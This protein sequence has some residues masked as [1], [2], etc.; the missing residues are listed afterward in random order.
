M[1]NLEG[2][3]HPRFNTRW[4]SLVPNFSMIRL[5]L[6]VLLLAVAVHSSL[7]EEVDVSLK[8]AE[9]SVQKTLKYPAALSDP[10]EAT[11]SDVFRISF[12][13][14]E[15]LDHVFLSM[16]GLRSQTTFVIGKKSSTSFAL[17][18]PIGSDPFMQGIQGY[19]DTYQLA[20]YITSKSGD[21]LKYPLGKMAV[22]VDE[23][24]TRRPSWLDAEYTQQPRIDH[25]FKPPQKM[26]SPT[27]SHVFTGLVVA[28]WLFFLPFAF[29][30]GLNAS[31]AARQVTYTL[32]A[33]L[34]LGVL[35]AWTFLFFL[36]FTEFNIF[37]LMGY[38]S[39]LAV[40]SVVVGRS[41]LVA[42][43]KLN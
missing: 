26:P 31:N 28:P 8:S 5:I 9:A 37:Q 14:E 22:S 35:A 43:A 34:F 40:I 13:S 2:V 18:H 10:L 15:D 17:E 19:N 20:L 39:V 29:K 1:H 38:G 41:A 23:S 25:E 11:A 36:Y 32:S 30:T 4:L 6:S 42:K 7:V 33:A 21:I 16:R 12:S 27:L 3:T 24:K